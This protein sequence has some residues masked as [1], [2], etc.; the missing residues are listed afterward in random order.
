MS[1]IVGTS[2]AKASQKHNDQGRRSALAGFFG[3]ALEY[4]DMY[5]FA[6]ASALVFSK[7]FFSD[8]SGATGLLLSLGTYGVAYLA[9]PLGGFL[10]GHFGDRLGRKNVMM[11]TLLVMGIATVLIGCLPSY[12][13]IGIFAPIAL[14]AL[15]LLQGLSVGGE[16]AGAATLAMEN[17]PENRR[18]LYTS[19]LVQGIWVGYIIATLAFIAVAAMPEEQLFSWGWRIPFWFSAVI[20]FIGLWIRR[21]VQEPEAFTEQQKSNEVAK[22]PIGVLLRYQSA[23]VIRLIFVAFLIVIS[24]V[25]PVY[26]LSY[27]VNTIGMK[28]SD[29]M[30][31]TVAAYG[32]ALITQPLFGML[33]DK[34]GR[35]PVL[36]MGNLIGAVAV[37]QFFWAVG[38]AN[39]AMIYVGMFL[40]ISLAFAC[41]NSVYPAFFAEQ[42]N[43]KF[44]MSGMAIGLQLGMVLTGF[45]PT[46]IQA[47]SVRNDG[48]WWPA[49]LFTSIACLISAVAVLTAR[50]T[51]KTPL[52]E[53][54]VK[55]TDKDLK[56]ISTTS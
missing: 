56:T 43:V 3:S 12:D 14:I 28:S 50:E 17:A 36:I 27:A 45:S 42:F 1:T 31:A 49:A 11:A 41:T 29:I 52:A 40:C 23:D 13:T 8:Q 46:I 6:S 2:S 30:W 34:I 55:L 53:L 44:R 48:A 16:M 35:K 33:S 32:L 10:A 54:G 26:G 38:N 22:A 20:V 15:R 18:G 9:R 5:I 4:Y 39:L 24:S 19:W 25:V 51:Y 7:V 47:M 21:R 37:W